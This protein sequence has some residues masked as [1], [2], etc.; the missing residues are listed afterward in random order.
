MHTMIF[1]VVCG[2][3]MRYTVLDHFVIVCSVLY[4]TRYVVLTV[5]YYTALRHSV[6]VATVRGHGVLNCNVDNVM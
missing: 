3:V 6:L 5:V 4:C 2:V 1:L